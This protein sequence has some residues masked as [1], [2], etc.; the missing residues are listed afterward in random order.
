[1]KPVMIVAAL[2]M[3]LTGCQTTSGPP[4]VANADADR[5]ECKVVGVTSAT[6]LNRAGDPRTVD[7]DDTRQTQGTLE[8]DR[9][10]AREP[11]PLRKAGAPHDS[12]IARMSRAC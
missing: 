4:A 9:L 3:A 8:A 12:T 2:V 10:G 7:R 11:P 1:M 6:Q 5:E